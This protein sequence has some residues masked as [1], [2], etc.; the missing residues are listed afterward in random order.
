MTAFDLR[1]FETGRRLRVGVISDSQLTPYPHKR[2]TTFERNLLA[3]FRT[4]KAY[5]CDMIVFAGDI[6]NRASK[7]GYKLFKRC[8]DAAFSGDKPIVQAIMGNHDYY[9]HPAPRRLFERE[10]GQKPLT[11]F[12]VNGVHF[13]G[14]SPDS[15]SMHRGYSETRGFIAERLAAYSSSPT[16]PRAPPF[17]APRLGATIPSRECSTDIR[18]WSLSQ[19]TLTFRCCT[20]RVFGGAA[21]PRSALSPSLTQSLKRARSTAASRRAPMP[22]LWVTSW[23]SEKTRSPSFASTC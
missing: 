19:V 16:T 6:C 13:I 18:A 7:N 15:P 3:S 9:F 1:K 10:L 21:L 14:A 4:L 11:H 23:S 8:L 5:G 22:R 17:T 12:V 20:P 2:P